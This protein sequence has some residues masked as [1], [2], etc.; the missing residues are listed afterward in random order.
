M[1]FL[2]PWALLLA[3]AAGVPLLLHLLRRRSGDKLDFPAVRYLLRMEREHARE[4][5]LKNMLLMVLRIAIVVALALAAARPVGWLPGVG[6]APSAVAIVLDNSLSSAAAGAEGQMLA[7]LVGAAGGIIDGSAAGDRLWLITMD[8]AVVG[9]DKGT[10]RAALSG[11]RALDGAG[12]AGAA[13]RRG[14][15][16][17]NESGIPSRH[18]VVL[19]DAQRTSWEGVV[20]TADA[21]VPVALI[22]PG[23]TVGLNRA[24]IAVATEPQH[25]DPRGTVRATVAGNDSA[26]WR[27]VLDGRTLAR[28]TAQPG[29]TVLARVQPP[30][31]GWVAGTVELAPDELR[32]DDTRHFAAH[33]GEPPAVTADPAS[34][35]FLRGA[36]DALVNGGRA[37][38]GDGVLLASAERARTPALLFAPADPVRVPDANR[39]L[40][41][42]GIPWR[43]GAR[44]DG[45]APLRGAGVDGAVAKSWHVLEAAGDVSKADTIARVGGA[46]WA[47]AGEGY[48][49][50]A[51]AAVADATD[52]P[53][54][55]SFLPWLD[56]LLAQRLTAGTAGVTESA[57]GRPVRVPALADALEA[58]DGSAVA[59]VPGATREAPWTAGVHFWRRGTER[60]GALVVN[61]DAS[62]SDLARLPADS[63]ATRLG[64][65]VASADPSA[66]ARAAFAAG[67]S[68]ALA[69]T[70]LLLALV[71][72]VAET[73]VARR[74]QAKSED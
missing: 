31:R 44:R 14:T 17:V 18:V 3:A 9:G 12:D 39:A 24:V 73:L 55:A 74:G 45:P 57:P 61:A 52:L 43:F 62:E 35:P 7:R 10:L 71:L 20:P 4:V 11:V 8:G 2:A 64:A 30:S 46:P 33:V 29:A 51:S 72:L 23:G 42:A 16:L 25:W 59:V 26:S 1:S 37:R 60:V 15:A 36:V 67:G 50:V 70:F 21:D 19:T 6:H 68:R 41:R 69:R 66:A 54:K 34:G 47:V 56:G 48:V 49:L 22:A 28:G 27:V 13:L 32:G 58:P 53:V 5:R 65:T 38:R 63:L 40:E